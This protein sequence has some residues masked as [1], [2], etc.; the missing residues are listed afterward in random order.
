[1]ANA[2]EHGTAHDRGAGLRH[3]FRHLV[4][5]HSHDTTDAVDDALATSREGLRA[6]W[7]SFLFLMLTAAAQAAVVALTGSVALLSDTLPAAISAIES[8]LV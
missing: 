1:M 8:L 7:L 3:R 2:G 5:P 4:T 6:L